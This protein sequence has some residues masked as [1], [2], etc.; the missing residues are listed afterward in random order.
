[1][2]KARQLLTIVVPYGIAVAICYLF[3]YWSRFGVNAL[4]YVGI[5]DVFK[6]AVFPMLIT[7]AFVMFGCLLGTLLGS[8]Q[9]GWLDRTLH[10]LFRPRAETWPAIVGVGVAAAAF[11]FGPEPLR[12]MLTALAMT[13]AVVSARNTPIA[14]SLLG[15]G[16]LAFSVLYFGTFL[17]L[18]AV[19]VGREEAR[20]VATGRGESAVD[21]SRST[22]RF[23]GGPKAPV[24]F[25]GTLDGTR[26]FY[27][28]CTDKT[29]VV[30]AT[31]TL[32][33]TARQTKPFDEP[34]GWFARTTNP[35]HGQCEPLRPTAGKVASERRVRPNPRK[36]P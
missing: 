14:Q 19:C 16:P 36:S 5:G 1:M 35:L 22:T 23:I 7:W 30:D 31:S 15:S 26:F 2:L 24:M 33:V 17:L 8:I 11:L 18:V 13:Y 20:R 29:I 21:I 4:E 28:T 27:E 6:L 25:L 3:G 10:A 34:W 12:W 32:V 9:I